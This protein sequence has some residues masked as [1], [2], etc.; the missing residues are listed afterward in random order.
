VV[1]GSKSN[2]ANYGNFSLTEI[3]DFLGKVV[4]QVQKDFK[5]L[6]GYGYVCNF[7]AETVAN[8]VKLD[9]SR[10][11]ISRSHDILLNSILT[12]FLRLIEVGSVSKKILGVNN[13]FQPLIAIL[14]DYSHNTNI[15]VNTL[16]ICSN[17]C[18]SFKAN[19]LQFAQSGGLEI[20]ICFLKYFSTNHRSKISCS[21]DDEMVLLATI[22]CLWT[23]VCGFQVNEE[24]FFKLKGVHLL[25]NL[26][27]MS[28]RV[29]KHLLGCITDLSENQKVSIHLKSAF[30]IYCSGEQVQTLRKDLFTF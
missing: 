24:E 14:K 9:R 13:I 17:L 18:E 30:H 11:D 15:L 20:L 27:E 19:K 8:G 3:F 12:F 5:N 23:T 1:G 25:L 22:E 26:F 2:F 16:L 4:V 28:K 6:E 29:K 7:F 10:T 21:S